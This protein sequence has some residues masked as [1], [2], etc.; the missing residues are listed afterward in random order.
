M[1]GPS[2][3]G[4]GIDFERVRNITARKSSRSP[5]C[6]CFSAKRPDENNTLPYLQSLARLKEALEILV[7]SKLRAADRVTNHI[8]STPSAYEGVVDR[9]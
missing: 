1:H 3:Q 5:P 8:V 9:G 6:S 2:Q 4:G 7:N